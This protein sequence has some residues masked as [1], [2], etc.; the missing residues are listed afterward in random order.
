MSRDLSLKTTP[1]QH[2]PPPAHDT[3]QPTTSAPSGN[4]R[5]SNLKVVPPLSARIQVANASRCNPWA[6]RG[7]NGYKQKPGLAFAA[8]FRSGRASGRFFPGVPETMR[9][10]RRFSA[11]L[12]EKPGK[13]C[14]KRA[15]RSGFC[16]K[17]SKKKPNTQKQKEAKTDVPPEP[18]LRECRKKANTPTY[19][20]RTRR[21]GANA[22]CAAGFPAK[23]A[24][25]TTCPA[26]ALK[27]GRP[28][29][30]APVALRALPG[31]PW[32]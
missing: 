4:R 1:T 24:A 18:H 16:R 21:P 5:R 9:A 12:P 3:P 11:W 17:K 2:W 29:S 14:K 32:P 30:V 8:P 25:S 6:R 7:A 22:P 20:S 23:A 15:R 27:S 31:A 13:R 26:A 28:E 10:I 19:A